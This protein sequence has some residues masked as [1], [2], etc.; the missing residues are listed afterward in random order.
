MTLTRRDFLYLVAATF[1]ALTWTLFFEAGVATSMYLLCTAQAA[2]D[3]CTGVWHATTRLYFSGGI[4]LAVV[5][6][7]LNLVVKDAR[8]VLKPASSSALAVVAGVATHLFVYMIS[9]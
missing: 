4:C 1:V 9:N 8:Q 5:L 7:F 6:L 3:E 2:A